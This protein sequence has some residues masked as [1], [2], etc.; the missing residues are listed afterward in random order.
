[1][2]ELNSS[3]TK[4]SRNPCCSLLLAHKL[5]IHLLRAS[6][7]VHF[8]GPF[9]IRG[10]FYE[11]EEGGGFSAFPCNVTGFMTLAIKKIIVQEHS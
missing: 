11:L 2:D 1:M 5:N 10:M 6:K 8:S 3:Y 9:L 7:G 4:P